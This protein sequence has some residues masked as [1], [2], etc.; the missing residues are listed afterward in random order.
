M[1]DTRSTSRDTQPRVAIACGGTGGHLYPGLAV[2]EELVRNGC[3]VTLL[4]SPKEVDQQAVRAISD[5]RVATLPAIGLTRGRVIAFAVGF[6]KSFRMSRQLFKKERPV[7]V[8]AMGGFTGASPVLAG[9][10][11]GARAFLHEANSVPGR[12]NR[13]ISRFT[14]RAFV[15]F[16]QA[17]PGLRRCKTEVAG[18][19]V[20]SQFFESID[21]VAARM[22]LGLNPNLPTV[23]FMGGSQ[24]ASRINELAIGAMATL[25]KSGIQ[26]LHLTGAREFARA[27][28]AMKA[29][30]CPG[31]VK[32]FLSEMDLA[33]GAATVTVS[34]SGASSL[35][36]VAAMRVP[37]I[38]I[39][40]PT[41]VDNHQ[42]FN[43]KAFVDDGAAI[44]ME[45]HK[46]TPEGL[47]RSIC[48]LIRN[49]EKRAAMASALDKWRHPEAAAN[50][51]GRILE[52]VA[53]MM[54][55]A[56]D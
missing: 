4:V 3:A 21:P 46:I 5:M 22:A 34:R 28:A 31:A 20:R 12:A 13:W 49:Q 52:S 32:E 53:A 45:Q 41:A 14:D 6:W 36:E 8:L 16:P 1:P 10:L 9:R 18:M 39:P 55:A 24:G 29:A 54:E 56:H 17:A 50:V 38:L 11:L 2:G 51:A 7:A 33:L 42:Y 37:A 30:E 35:A 27:K 25:G 48:E 43:A 23:L 26:V 40:F 44:L 15:Y 19:P 47:A